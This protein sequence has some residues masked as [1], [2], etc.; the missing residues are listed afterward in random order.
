MHH[1]AVERFVKNSLNQIHHKAKKGDFPCDQASKQASWILLIAGIL[2]LSSCSKDEPIVSPLHHDPAQISPAFLK[3]QETAAGLAQAFARD[4]NSTPEHRKELFSKIANKFD[5]DFDML[6]D[7]FKDAT[8]DEIQTSIK[9]NGLGKTSGNCQVNVRE[10]IQTIPKLQLMVPYAKNWTDRKIQDAGGLI[11]AY[12][13]FGVPESKIK[14]IVG[15]DKN[16]QRVVINERSAP[17]IPYVILSQNERTDNEGFLRLQLVSTG[18]GA[19]PAAKTASLS[20]ENPKLAKVSELENWQDVNLGLL[21]EEKGLGA[22][23]TQTLL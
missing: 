12:Y 10:A 6:V 22:I 17:T 7:H 4:F 16:G 2:V 9:S 3:M 18:F 23:S 5:G 20:H 15:F 19:I 1:N 13:P 8:L 14:E 21:G 11:V